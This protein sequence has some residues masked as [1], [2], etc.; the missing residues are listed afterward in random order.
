MLRLVLDGELESVRKYLKTF[1][2]IGGND[3]FFLR[4]RKFGPS[5][6]HQARFKGK[7]L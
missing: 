2:R 5:I 4:K 7:F 6:L 3:K 1:F